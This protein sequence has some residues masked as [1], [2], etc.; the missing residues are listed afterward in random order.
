M[1]EIKVKRSSSG[2]VLV[3]GSNASDSELCVYEVRLIVLRYDSGL[4]Q[5]FRSFVTGSQFDTEIEKLLVQT[6]GDQGEV[7]AEA[8]YGIVDKIATASAK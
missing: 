6:S 8:Y 1:L 5:Y 7:N 3:Y 4:T 2:E